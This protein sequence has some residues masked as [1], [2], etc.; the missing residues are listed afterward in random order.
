MTRQYLI[1]SNGRN[2]PGKVVSQFKMT[3]MFGGGLTATGKHFQVEL[4]THFRVLP[5]GNI[6]TMIRFHG[7][8]HRFS[9][10]LLNDISMLCF[11]RLRFLQE[12]ATIS[13]GSL[14][15]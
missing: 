12:L 7:V 5:D 10:D 2:V 14:I 4:L 8:F 3:L 6:R 9:P 13:S 11:R 1:Q 15:L